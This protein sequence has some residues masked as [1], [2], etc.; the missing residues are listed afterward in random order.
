VGIVGGGRWDATF[1]CAVQE[2]WSLCSW[3]VKGWMTLPAVSMN[4]CYLF[5][6]SCCAAGS[7]WELLSRVPLVVL[8]SAAVQLGMHLC[9]GG[10]VSIISTHLQL[11]KCY[12]LLQSQQL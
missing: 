11:L 12:L 9:C 3:L 6:C 1:S 10:N 5:K 8:L 7:A 2:Y 4:S